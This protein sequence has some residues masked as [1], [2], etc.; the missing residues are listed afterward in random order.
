M[1]KEMKSDRYVTELELS[2]RPLVER[3][4]IFLI[5]PFQLLIREPIVMSVAVYMSVLYGTLYMFFVAFPV[6]YMEGKG[7]SSGIT[8]LMFIPFAVGGVLSAACAPLVNKHYLTLARKHNG[9]PPA[10][11]RLIP[12]MVRPAK[13]PS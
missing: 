7:Y 5:R 9:K 2:Q 1:R 10:E 11:A 12:M 13:R 8:G 3:L 6:I 4:R